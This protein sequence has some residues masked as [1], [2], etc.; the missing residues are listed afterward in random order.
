MSLL[1]VIYP[2]L[3]MQPL[4]VTSILTNTDNNFAL[5]DGKIG[6]M[7]FKILSNASGKSNNI[8]FN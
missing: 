2:F 7:K 5:N 6:A 3:V 4:L 1:S 8:L